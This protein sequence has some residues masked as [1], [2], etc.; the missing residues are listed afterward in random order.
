MQIEWYEVTHLEYHFDVDDGVISL[1]IE[2]DD[3]GSW[4]WSGH[5][6]NDR[7]TRFYNISDHAVSIEEA[8]AAAQRWLDDHQAVLEAIFQSPSRTGA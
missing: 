7:T 6:G 8:K 1:D 4:F 3:G 2:P 5:I